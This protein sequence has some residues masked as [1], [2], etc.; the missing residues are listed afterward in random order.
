M[1]EAAPIDRSAM[2]AF[3]LDHNQ[4]ER[5]IAIDQLRTM[6]FGRVL[7]AETFSDAWD[8]LENQSPAL[9]VLEWS[10][11]SDP[12]DFVRRIRASEE[13]PNRALAVF[14]L[15]Q[16]GTRADVESARQAGVDGFLRKPIS[17]LALDRRV[18]VVLTKPRP[19]VATADYVGPCRRRR[20]SEAYLGPF[21]RLA[22]AA[23]ALEPEELDVK[24]AVARAS[25]AALEAAVAGLAPGEPDTARAVYR[26]VQDLADVGERIGDPIVA[27]GAHEMARY[28]LAQG[29]TE[30]LDP[31]VVRTHV[32]AL[33]Q[34]VHLPHVLAEERDNVAKS[35]KRMVDKKLRGAA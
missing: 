3:V 23:Q 11:A 28:V 32:A 34:L 1:T 26:A 25:V 10:E 22:D 24:A 9:A 19:F 27:F 7:P 18:R 33:H 35:L 15:T 2:S 31:E 21:R 14:V 20:V 5:R 8:L 12:L 30:R 6:G 13:L 29:A 4:Y 16:R 17:T